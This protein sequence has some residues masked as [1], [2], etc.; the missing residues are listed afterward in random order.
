MKET[1][2]FLSK[3]PKPIVQLILENDLIDEENIKTN[4]KALNSFINLKSILNKKN[5]YVESSMYP[6]YFQMYL[7][8]K[9]YLIRQEIQIKYRTENFRREDYIYIDIKQID[10][11]INE[12]KNRKIF[13]F[14]WVCC[15]TNIE[16]NNDLITKY[17]YLWNWDY[18]HTNPNISWNFDLIRNNL[19]FVNWSFVSSY[20]ELKWT[21]ELLIEFEDYLVFSISHWGQWGIN[22][23]GKWNTGIRKASHSGRHYYDNLK[24]SISLSESIEWSKGIIDSVK[25]Y[26]NWSELSSNKTVPWDDYLIEYYEEKID[27]KAI[28]GN[29]NVKWTK[30]LIKKYLDKW[31]W[32]LL[33]GNPN[34]PWDEEFLIEYNSRFLW[35]PKVDYFL[36]RKDKNYPSSIS[37][38]IGIVWDENLLELFHENINF[39]DITLVSK[40]TD[41]A[42]IKFKDSFESEQM[43]GTQNHRYSDSRVTEWKSRNGWENLPLNPN[44]FISK[45]NIDFYL[46][47]K[48]TINYVEGNLAEDGDYTNKDVT[49]LEVLKNSNL[50]DIELIDIIKNETSWGK[51][52][53]NENFA[54]KSI[55]LKIIE[56]FKETQSALIYINELHLHTL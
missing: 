33:S 9:D 40:I 25:E 13:N 46:N 55:C 2:T 37:T 16:W 41:K 22:K 32:E 17:N 6:G 44:F 42:I 50:Q 48:T 10:N 24:G 53:L 56:F 51:F 20:L 5:Y 54:N 38:N 3:Y 43:V 45:N 18:L 26:W 21:E 47:N 1:I 31:D 4:E 30:I 35:K 19:D 36:F 11:F 34:L 49:I 7:G 12:Y 8:K 27:F 29:I 39:W 14:D 52:L 23:K 15:E 28:S